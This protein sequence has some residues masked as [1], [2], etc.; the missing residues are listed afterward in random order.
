MKKKFLCLLS[1][2][3]LGFS[4]TPNVYAATVDTGG[5]RGLHTIQN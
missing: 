3:T 1:V 5:K 4:M 2:F